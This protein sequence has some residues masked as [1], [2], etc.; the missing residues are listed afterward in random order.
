MS[1]MPLAARKSATWRVLKSGDGEQRSTFN[2]AIDVGG[3]LLL[4]QL[5][6]A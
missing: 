2:S 4:N 5:K 6:A 1:S 3:H